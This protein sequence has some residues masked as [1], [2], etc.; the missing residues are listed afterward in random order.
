MGQVLASSHA[1]GALIED[2]LLEEAIQIDLLH[3]PSQESVP[4]DG[5]TNH[6]KV[7][8]N[9]VKKYHPTIGSS[10]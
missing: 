1:L 3:A 5:H 9:P 10:D 8:H 7:C 2:Y 4:E 6:L